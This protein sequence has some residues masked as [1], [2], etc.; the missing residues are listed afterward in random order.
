VN[1]QFLTATLPAGQLMNGSGNLV[2]SVSGTPSIGGSAIFEIEIGGK[3]CQF[4]F[5]VATLQSQYAT[6][7]IF[8]ASGPTIII[9]VTNPTT[10]KIWMDRNIGA[11]QVATSSNDASAYGD[12]FQW[13]RR[14]DG[15]QCRTSANTTT[16]STTDQ[17]A[18]GNFILAST[19]P[20]DWRNPQNTNLWQGTNGLNNPCPT[21]YRLPTETEL[22]N[23]R[24]SWGAN[25]SSAAFSSPLKLPVGG[26]RI[27]NT[28][29]IST[30]GQVGSYWSSSINSTSSRNLV[31]DTST[32]SIVSNNRAFG[33]SIRCIK[34]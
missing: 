11:T 1:G 6:G 34:N 16:L 28:G 27:N 25:S 31:I 21:G 23:E 14:S 8:C 17:P 3:N 13:G 4:S 18:N 7:S 5:P 32:S 24:A 22:D 10:G 19:S 33:C 26:N 12:L 20:F 9:D 30:A 29:V 2:F 15:H